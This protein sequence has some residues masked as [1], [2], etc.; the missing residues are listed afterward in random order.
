MANIDAPFG[1]R[2]VGNIGGGQH[3]TNQFLIVDNEATSIFQ[4]DIVEPDENNAGYIAVQEATTNEDNLGV[5]NGVFITKDPTSGKPTFSNYY[6]QTNVATGE[7]I[8]AF[9]YDDP[10]M[11]FEIQGDSAT[12]AAQTDINKVADSVAT[13]SGSTANGRSKL[14]LDVSD[15]QT[16]DGQLKAVAFSSDPENNEMATHCNY[17]VIFNEHQYK[18]EL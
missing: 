4:G 7:E 15:F 1:L 17:V 12:A 6:S 10:F 3:M 9:V 11:K 8:R 16:T 14:E 18:K 13:H 2:P 5:F